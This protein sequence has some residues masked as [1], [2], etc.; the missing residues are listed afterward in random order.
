[1]YGILVLEMQNDMVLENSPVN[2]GEMSRAIVPNIQRLLTIARANDTPVVYANLTCIPGD[3]LFQRYPAAH[4]IPGTSGVE[5]IAELKPQEEDYVVPIY[6]MDAFIHTGLEHILRALDITTLLVTGNT[7]EVSCLLTAMGAFQRGFDVIVVTDC[8]A[9][10]N[11]ERHQLGLN[12]LKLFA[13]LI[14]QLTLDETIARLE[15]RG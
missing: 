4:C 11:E 1:M 5:V 3:P 10:W 6:R 14:P 12:Y 2:I 13:K 9:S 8:C 15:S 7:T